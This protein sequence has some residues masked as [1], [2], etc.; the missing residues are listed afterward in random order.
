M[1]VRGQD[2]MARM[3][4]MLAGPNPPLSLPAAK[5]TP[6]LSADSRPHLLQS[7]G[8]LYLCTATWAK[9]VGSLAPIK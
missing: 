2:P 6:P 9:P 3:A 5:T 4:G 8:I 7:D 1:R